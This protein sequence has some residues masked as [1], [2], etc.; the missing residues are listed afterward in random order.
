VTHDMWLSLI[1]VLA[2]AVAGVIAVLLYAVNKGYKVEP[3]TATAPKKAA[4]SKADAAERTQLE[5]V[6]DRAS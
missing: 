2:L 4:A 3:K 6:R 5:P 1:G